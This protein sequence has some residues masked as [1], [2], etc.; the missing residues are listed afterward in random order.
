MWQAIL[1]GID[2]VV[3]IDGDEEQCVVLVRQDKAATG[4]RR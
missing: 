4:P 3:D 2:D 1:L